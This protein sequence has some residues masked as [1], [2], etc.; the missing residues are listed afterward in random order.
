[1]RQPTLQSELTQ[2]SAEHNARVN[3]HAVIFKTMTTMSLHTMSVI[4]FMHDSEWGTLFCG[5]GSVA[6]SNQPWPVEVTM[7]RIP[8]PLAV[9]GLFA[10]VLLA[11]LSGFG[12]DKNK[13]DT[14]CKVFFTVYWADAHIPGG[15]APGMH[16]EQKNWYEKKLAKK[17]PTVCMNA[18]KANYAIIWSSEF[19]PLSLTLPVYHQSATSISGDVNATATMGWYE[20]E[21]LQSKTNNVYMFIFPLNR[22]AETSITPND[23]PIFATHH[24]SW[25]TYRAA[26]RKALEDAMKFLCSLA[27]K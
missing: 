6:K 21:T 17:Y 15:Y 13:L 4:A 2:S 24:E 9:A 20:N 7:C 27:E 8:H 22:A 12:Q 19:K 26:H 3:W 11:S 5:C 14:G 16:K 25:W 10:F 18:E 23:K 1:L